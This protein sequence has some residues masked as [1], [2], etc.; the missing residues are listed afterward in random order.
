[1]FRKERNN[2]VFSVWETFYLLAMGNSANKF[3]KALQQGNEVNACQLY[4]Q[5]PDIRERLDPNSSHKDSHL[6]NTPLHYVA[7][8]GM[9]SLLRDFLARGG[10]PNK[11]NSLD[12]TALHMLM[13]T[14]SGE[15]DIVDQRRLDCLHLLLKWR[16]RAAFDGVE[17]RLNLDAVDQVCPLSRMLLV[18]PLALQ[19]ICLKCETG[20]QNVRFA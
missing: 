10:N 9:K 5:N 13:V 16:G 15:M 3:R 8:Y 20:F 1:M 4:V 6:H 12:Q 14:A 18:L 17:E 2:T 19:S 7:K 11:Q